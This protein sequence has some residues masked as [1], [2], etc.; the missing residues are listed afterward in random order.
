MAYNTIYLLAFSLAALSQANGNLVLQP[1]A[2]APLD[3][4]KPVDQSFPSFG[5]QVSSFPAF[6]GI[7]HI[8]IVPY[9]LLN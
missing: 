6:T 3:S 1:K 9:L 2:K 5:I 8:S 4:S 7:I